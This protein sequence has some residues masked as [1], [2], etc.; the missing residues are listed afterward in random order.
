MWL[1]LHRRDLATRPALLRD[2]FADR[3]PEDVQVPAHVVTTDL[4]SGTAHVIS[5]GPVVGALL[6]SA[7]IPGLFPPVTIDGCHIVDGPLRPI[8]RS[9]KP[10]TWAPLTFSSS[11]WPPGGAPMPRTAPPDLALSGLVSMVDAGTARHPRLA[12]PGAP[13]ASP[14]PAQPAISSTFGTPHLIAE[15]YH[16]TRRWLAEA[17]PAAT[18]AA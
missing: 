4:A 10:W 1:W 13:H 9:A 14:Y 7:A 8:P 2:H 6:A 3:R 12:S 17:R 5:A 11:R 18:A 16:L 15:S